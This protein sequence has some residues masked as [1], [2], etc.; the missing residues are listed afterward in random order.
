MIYGLKIQ[1]TGVHMAS[2]ANIQFSWAASTT[3][4]VTNQTLTVASGSGSGLTTI[5]GVNLPPSSIS[6]NIALP[7]NTPITATLNAVIMNGTVAL[8]SPPVVVSFNTGPVN[9]P[10]SPSNFNYQIVS[11][12]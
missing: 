10:N 1:Q 11:V 9:P 2:T 8:I 6:Y 4:G 12:S 3:P 7:A 5:T